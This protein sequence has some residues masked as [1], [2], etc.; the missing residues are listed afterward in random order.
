LCTLLQQ[1]QLLLLLLL[2]LLL[3]LLLLLLLPRRPLRHRTLLCRVLL[4]RVLL[5]RVLRC[6]VL[7]MPL[8]LRRRER[9]GLHATQPPDDEPPAQHRLSHASKTAPMCVD[10]DRVDAP[11]LMAL[12]LEAVD[13]QRG[14][15]RLEELRSRRQR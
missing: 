12:V 15:R 14:A 5:F 6:R 8:R 3:M 13:A 9:M 1:Q 4:C 2:L 7:R 11:T 10:V